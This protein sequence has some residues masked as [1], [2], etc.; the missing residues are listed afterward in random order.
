MNCYAPIE[1]GRL[2]PIAERAATI[3]SLVVHFLWRKRLGFSR[4]CPAN[5]R[6]LTCGHNEFENAVG[7]LTHMIFQQSSM[8]RTAI[9]H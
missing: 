2:N 3:R 1:S 5:E 9:A 4:K 8:I 6:D 7:L